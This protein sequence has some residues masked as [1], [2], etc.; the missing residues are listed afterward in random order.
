MKRSTRRIAILHNP[1]TLPPD[2]PD[3]ASEASVVR[4]ARHVT[5]A[6]RAAGWKAWP[7]AARAPLPRLVRS[8]GRQKPDVVYNLVE[9][10]A[11]TSAGEPWA[12][13]VLELMGIPYTGCPPEAQSL[14][15]HK[16]RTK[17]LLRGA[18]LPTAP[19]VLVGPGDPTPTPGFLPG[20]ERVIVKPAAEDASLGIDQRSVVD[21]TDTTFLD[22][23]INVLRNDYG[24]EVLLEAYLAGREFNVGVLA[25][26]VPTALPAA[27]VTYAPGPN[28]W[29][30]LTYEAKWSEGSA[31]DR[32]SPV[33]CPAELEPG[34]AE[35]LAEL[36]VAAFRATGC[37]DYAR[38]DFR[39]D[40]SGEPMILE[41]NPN[42]D[43]DPAAGFAR[44]LGAAG[45]AYGSTIEGLV[46]QALSRG[47]SALRASGGT[48][49]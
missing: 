22:D 23:R 10:Y 30:I 5:D 49:S 41:V 20:V 39:L 43:L 21:V 34:L 14:C 37:R 31:D 46:R 15:R 42:P 7:L 19:F 36:A 9:G 1:P 47:S 4:V 6:L 40:D 11:G 8:L 26:P 27:E 48:G 2:H 28:T 25:T 45:L 18:G 44:A 3:H 33:R 12:T 13:G 24:S 35:R 38:V 17:A 29:P 32:A 16:G